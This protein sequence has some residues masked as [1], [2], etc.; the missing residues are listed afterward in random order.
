MDYTTNKILDDISNF[1]NL[2]ML[3][4][5]MDN[6]TEEQFEE[7]SRKVNARKRSRAYAGMKNP[8]KKMRRGGN[9]VK[10]LAKSSISLQMKA[11]ISGNGDSGDVS[12]YAGG[13]YSI[14]LFGDYSRWDKVDSS[15]DG[16]I[17][18]PREIESILKNGANLKATSLLQSDGQYTTY[19]YSVKTSITNFATLWTMSYLFSIGKPKD[20]F[21]I[22]AIRMNVEQES[23][24]I[25]ALRGSKFVIYSWS[26]LGNP[27]KQEI[28]LLSLV[29]G[30]DF[31]KEIIDLSVE[32]DIGSDDLLVLEVPGGIWNDTSN[33]IDFDVSIK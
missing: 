22:N 20:R 5:S 18:A 24:V 6:M 13:T 12:V 25:Q 17:Q 27:N 32:M 28:P 14:P 9:M 30:K 29:D 4:S 1:D 10:Q 31:S 15:T 7:L 16:Y 8:I 3:E 21:T 19:S 11:V 33:Q 23:A 2:D 26:P